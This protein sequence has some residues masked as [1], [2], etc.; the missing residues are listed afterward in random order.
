MPH[1]C[2][3]PRMSASSQKHLDLDRI[4]Q[5]KT[6]TNIFLTLHGGSGSDAKEF[7]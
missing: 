3:N 6:A 4:Q 5:I 7:D 2:T 1:V